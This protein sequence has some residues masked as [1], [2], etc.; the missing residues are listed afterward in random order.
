M[1]QGRFSFLEAC[2][3]RS[4]LKFINK[5]S[6]AI[7]NQLTLGLYLPKLIIDLINYDEETA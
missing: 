1:T 2:F 7:G 5:N 4:A 3:Q 6:T